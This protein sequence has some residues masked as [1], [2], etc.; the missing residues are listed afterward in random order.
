MRRG[1][2]PIPREFSPPANWHQLYARLKDYRQQLQAPVDTVGCHC[3]RD[4]TAPKETQRFHVLVALMLSSQTKDAVTAA[5]MGQLLKV[6]LTPQS[7]SAMPAVELDSHICKVG[8]HN[9]KT[10]HIKEVADI[11]LQDH[12]AKVPGEY[13]ELIALPGVGPKM[14]HL[15]LQAADNRVLG[16]G[17]DT[18]VHR[19]SQRLRMVPSTVRSPEDTRK[20]LE[21]WLPRD[22]WSTINHLLVG[23]GQTVCLP[24]NPRCAE[25]KLNSVCPNAFKEGERVSAKAL[26]SGRRH[27]EEDDSPRLV[28]DMED[29]VASK[30]VA[31]SAAPPARKL[32]G[33]SGKAR[34]VR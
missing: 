11:L 23:L 20:A 6:G 7:I 32:K 3:L 16:I 12:N 18:H 29:A 14:A 26:S 22:Q 8:F 9:T 4:P 30:R 33:N 17:V 31:S 25:C 13:D 15:F 19:I 27:R 28:R 21:S 5:A 24:V 1:R 2:S 10:K 34:G